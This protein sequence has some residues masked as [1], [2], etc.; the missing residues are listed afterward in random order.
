MVSWQGWLVLLCF[1]Q[2]QRRLV[3]LHV[4]LESE[5]DTARTVSEGKSRMLYNVPMV[6]LAGRIYL[7]PMPVRIRTCSSLCPCMTGIKSKVT[8]ELCIKVTRRL[9]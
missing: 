7:L 8:L 2:G 3:L 4:H 1:V 9:I 5:T 6:Y